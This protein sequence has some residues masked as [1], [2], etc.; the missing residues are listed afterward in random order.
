MRHTKVGLNSATP[1]PDAAW[2]HNA[3]CTRETLSDDPGAPRCSDDG[4]CGARWLFASVK[5][6]VSLVSEVLWRNYSRDA[7]NTVY[8]RYSS[9]A[10]WAALR[11][12]RLTFRARSQNPMY[13]SRRPGS[14]RFR[15]SRLYTV[16]N[17]ARTNYVDTNYERIR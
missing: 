8:V 10:Q 7:P 6:I 13:F 14:V 15:R 16:N 12:A 5:C 17:T 9:A 1:A 3:A 4:T 2:L 11:R